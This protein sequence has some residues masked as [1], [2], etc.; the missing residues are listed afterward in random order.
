[1]TSVI[2][3]ER[4][5]QYEVKD[6]TMAYDLDI[7]SYDS[8]GQVSSHVV[9][10]SGIIREGSGRFTI[11]GHVE[12]NTNDSM[13][14]ETEYLNWSSRDD[15]IYTDAYVR[16]TTPTE[17]VRGWGMEADQRLRRYKILHQVSGRL[18]E[19]ERLAPPE[20]QESP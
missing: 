17:V 18:D 3:A 12:V 10:D 9:G 7:T 13:H 8:L 15:R 14:L 5:T 20:S 19:T 6:S 1:V 11:F 16:I 4:I 2:N